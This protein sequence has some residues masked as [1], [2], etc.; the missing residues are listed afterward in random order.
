[1][2]KASSS[3]WLF[4]A[5]MVL[6]VSAK[7]KIKKIKTQVVNDC[8]VSCET[9]V[10]END[11]QELSENIAAFVEEHATKVKTLTD[12]GMYLVKKGLRTRSQR[13]VKTIRAAALEQ[14]KKVFRK[15]GGS[16]ADIANKL[17]SLPG[18]LPRIADKLKNEASSAARGVA[19]D[20]IQKVNETIGSVGRVAHE[21]LNEGKQK[22]G[23]VVDKMKKEAGGVVDKMKKEAG[24]VVDTVKKEAEDVL[25]KT[26]KKAEDIGKT[27]MEIVKDLG[28]TLT[29]WGK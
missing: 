19:N 7:S 6:A 9:S 28:S 22:L 5:L 14:L 21:T 12:I 3:C 10:C 25:D 4:F 24:G 18:E 11:I 2:S 15:F 1:M 26:K 13:F 8:S 29:A 23:G 16:F 27:G 17:S 20:G